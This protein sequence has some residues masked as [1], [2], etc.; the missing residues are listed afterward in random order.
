MY[1]DLHKSFDCKLSNFWNYQRLADSPKNPFR[2]NDFITAVFIAGKLQ[3]IASILR[4]EWD[5]TTRAEE[6]EEVIKWCTE[7]AEAIL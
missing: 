2:K 5:D 3:M 1:H 7:T 4:K 6:V